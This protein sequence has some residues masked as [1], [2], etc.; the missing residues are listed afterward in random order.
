MLYIDHSYAFIFFIACWILF[1]CD[2][3]NLK[4]LKDSRRELEVSYKISFLTL[5][6][7]EKW[8]NLI[9]TYSFQLFQNNKNKRD[10]IKGLLQN[11][12]EM[13]EKNWKSNYFI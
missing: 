10:K 9:S 7:F 11:R 4:Q 5:F 6:K 1:G 13:L 8:I 12:G 2:P 3:R